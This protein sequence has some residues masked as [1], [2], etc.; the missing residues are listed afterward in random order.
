MGEWNDR[1]GSRAT[2][3]KV[4]VGRGVRYYSKLQVAEFKIEAA[5]L[6]VGDRILVTGPTTGALEHRAQVIKGQADCRDR[7]CLPAEAREHSHRPQGEGQ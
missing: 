4:Y 2:E 7:I 1:P 3:R 5:P 6:S